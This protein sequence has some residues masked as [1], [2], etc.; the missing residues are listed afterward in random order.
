VVNFSNCF[1]SYRGFFLIFQLVLL[2]IG[3]YCL[4]FI[5]STLEMIASCGDSYSLLSSYKSFAMIVHVAL[6]AWLHIG[7]ASD[8][9]ELVSFIRSGRPRLNGGKLFGLLYHLIFRV[10]GSKV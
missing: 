6:A 10:D 1:I 8:I 3:D 5:R 2:A 7:L 9:L 4:L